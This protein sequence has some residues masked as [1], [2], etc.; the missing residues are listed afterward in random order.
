MKVKK[1]KLGEKV[2]DPERQE[3]IIIKGP[4][5]FNDEIRKEIEENWDDYAGIDIDDPEMTEGDWYKVRVIDEESEDY[6]KEIWY[7]GMELDI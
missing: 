6:G 3:S 5:H 4:V 1:Y 2:M 7:N